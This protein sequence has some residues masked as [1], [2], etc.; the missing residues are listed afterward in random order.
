MSGHADYNH[1]IKLLVLG[2]SAVGKSSLLMRFCDDKFEQNFVITIGVDYK[3]KTIERHNKKLRIQVWDTAGQ[4]RFRTIT[5]AYYR[6]A[7]G[8]I[9]T[10][11]ITDENSF[12]NVEF[13]M[14]NLAA[15]GDAEVQCVLVGNKA[16]LESKRQVPRERGEDL[17][18]KYDMQLFETSAKTASDVDSAFN[19]IAD[20]VY[21]KRFAHLGDERSNKDHVNLLS[22]KP[23]TSKCKC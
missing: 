8:V 18:R 23:D 17:A 10:Y 14:R 6:S 4:E 13:W 3:M 19:H 12:N 9:M 20:L 15:H 11:D 5:P 16:D 22:S 21:A 7:M 2:D 1:L